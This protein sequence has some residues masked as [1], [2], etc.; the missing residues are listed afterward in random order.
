MALAAVTLLLLALVMAGILGWAKDAFHVEVDPKVEEISLALPG[1]NCGGCGYVGCTDYA[2][3]V[4]GGEAELTLCGP[5]GVSCAESIA[6]IMGQEITATFPYRAVVHCAA[7]RDVRLPLEK[8]EY[9]GE[10]TCTA[11]NLVAGLQ[12]C[13]YGCLGLGDCA[14]ACEY[15]AI[16]V[17]EGLAVVDYD[18]CIGCKACAVVC[19]RNIISMVPFKADRMLVVACSNLDAGPAVKAVCPIGCISCSVCAKKSELVA[20]EGSLPVIDYHA[21]E[22]ED[23]FAV[24][25]EKCPR[26]SL[27]FVGKP[28]DEDLAKVEEEE[29]PNRIKADFK[30]TVD[31]TE[32]RG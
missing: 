26:E 10:A 11:A 19:P 5:G 3:A 24:S 6:E 17:I 21:Y 31:D 28:S 20:M 25:V 12:G 14:R 27:I 22:N 16:H 7:T 1:A 8:P 30:T 23:D 2:E 18:K 32:W 4:A 15:D 9:H 29:L 13:T